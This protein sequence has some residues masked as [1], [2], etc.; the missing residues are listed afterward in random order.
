MTTPF[1]P[2]AP[3]PTKILGTDVV[4][5]NSLIKNDAPNCTPILEP[6]SLSVEIAIKSLGTG[7]S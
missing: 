5:K 6:S 2:G 4:V 3:I 1:A 7:I